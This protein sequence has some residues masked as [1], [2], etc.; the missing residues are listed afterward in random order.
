MDKF[1]NMKEKS[2]MILEP[3]QVM[4]QLALLSH[5]PIGTK[6]SVSNNL[7]PA[8]T[9]HSIGTSPEIT[10]TNSLLNEKKETGIA[11]MTKTINV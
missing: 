4:I 11:K 6:L 9:S 8:F 3:L 10:C 2:D 1:I 7:S 5:S